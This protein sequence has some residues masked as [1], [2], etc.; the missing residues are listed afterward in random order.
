MKGPKSGRVTRAL[1]RQLKTS[2]RR[3]RPGTPPPKPL[4]PALVIPVHNDA[5]G[6]ARLLD[7]ARDMDCFGQI[8]VV[9]DG[10]TPPVSSAPGITLLRH[11]TPQGGGVARNLGLTAVTCDHVLFFDADDL[12]TAN[13]AALLVTLGSAGG[14]DFCQF[15]YAD[16]R[17][18][19]EGLWGQPDWDEVFWEDAQAAVGHLREAPP[20]TWPI[21]VQTANY[22]WNKIYRTDFLRAHTIGCAATAVHQ[23]VP[24]HWLGYLA[25]TRVLTSDRIC[26][27][28]EVRA[29]GARL[30]NRTGPER[31]ELFAALTPVAEAAHAKGAD[32]H[33]ALARFTLGLTDW[34]LARIEPDLA[35]RMTAMER[36]WLAAHVAPWLAGIETIDASLAARLDDRMRRVA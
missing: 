22:P 25:A 14:F 29:G 20:D 8:V 2:L 16:S 6:L 7:Q 32:W 30:T 23:D 28:H 10:S 19:A 9:D 5:A 21:L 4:R 12:L 33:A 36:D 34:G 35:P 24:L 3:L 31:L 13:L 15:K 11:D 27:W 1:R 18:G 17:V 26:A